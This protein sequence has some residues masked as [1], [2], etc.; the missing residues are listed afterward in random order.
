[1]ST[2]R[3]AAALADGR[4]LHSD[5]CPTA[6][7]PSVPTRR[8]ILHPAP[9]PAQA[10]PTTF[11]GWRGQ[12]VTEELAAVPAPRHRNRPARRSACRHSVARHLRSALV[13]TLLAVVAVTGLSSYAA[14]GVPDALSTALR[15]AR[16][17]CR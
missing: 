3:Q 13:G 14:A 15:Q 1:M 12:A 7:I 11:E 2:A 8:S 5:D 9:A 17:S 10:G 16:T 4:R 6:A